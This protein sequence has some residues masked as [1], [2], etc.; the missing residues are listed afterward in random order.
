[1]RGGV[2]MAGK[3]LLEGKKI[4]IVDDEPDV[5]DTLEDLLSMSEVEK[6]SS[7]EEASRLLDT[8]HFDMAVLDIMGVNGYQLLAICNQ[9][10]LPAVMLTSHALNPENLVKSFKLGAASF[11]PKD[12]I[13]DITVFLSDALRAKE[14]GEHVWSSWAARLGEAYWRNKF[15]PDWQD[16]DKKFWK[17]FRSV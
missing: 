12:R 13:A 8:E 7:F 11:V 3:D 16:K 5:L 14:K 6:A 15:G 1:M 9:K 10:N 17:E 2:D 4:L